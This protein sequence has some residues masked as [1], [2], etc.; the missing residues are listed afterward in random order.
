MRQRYRHSS[1]R[2]RRVRLYVERFVVIGSF[3]NIFCWKVFWIFWVYYKNIF[4]CQQKAFWTVWGIFGGQIRGKRKNFF[5][6]EKSW[7]RLGFCVLLTMSSPGSSENGSRPQKS[8]RSPG[9]SFWASKRAKVESM[10]AEP[11]KVANADCEV[12]NLNEEL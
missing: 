8:K 3:S 2:V 11:Q 10:E 6:S 12:A 4:K 5:L 9:S 1:F 7:F